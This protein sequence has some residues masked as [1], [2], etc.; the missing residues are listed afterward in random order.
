[1]GGKG[2]GGA[3]LHGYMPWRGDFETEYENDAEKLLADMEFSPT[4]HPA[5]RALKHQVIQIYN[6]KVCAPID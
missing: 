1:T 3:H 4:D 6:R 2:D 5:E